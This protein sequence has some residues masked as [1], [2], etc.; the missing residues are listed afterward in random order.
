M[1]KDKQSLRDFQAHLAERLASA[2]QAWTASKLGLLV[3]GQPW[4]T[5]LSAVSEVVSE[6]QIVPVPWAKPWFLGLTNVRGVIYGCTDLAGFMGMDV[7][8]EWGD[9]RLLIV[10]PRH[11]LNA[12]LR[13]EGT[14]GL[15]NIAQMTRQVRPADAPPWI[16]AVWRGADER[17]WTELNIG[18]LVTSARFLDAGID[19]VAMRLIM[20]RSTNHTHTLER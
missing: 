10:H 3:G 20:S 7:A 4:L 9:S 5:E 19:R 17:I 12:A 11:G 14:L 2:K 18:G 8:G 15:F 1:G 13:I 16:E 6:A